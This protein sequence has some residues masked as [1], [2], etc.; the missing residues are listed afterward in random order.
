M[1]CN[2]ICTYKHPIKT[3]NSHLSSTTILAKTW[4][5]F[6]K[7]KEEVK[8]YIGENREGEKVVGL[9]PKTLLSHAPLHSSHTSMKSQDT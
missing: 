2:F 4:A 6:S 9:K 5:L 8:F 7:G 1:F 3:S